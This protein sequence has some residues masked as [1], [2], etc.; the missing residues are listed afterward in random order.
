MHQISLQER[1]RGAIWGQFIGDGATSST[2]FIDVKKNNDFKHYGDAA[3]LLLHSLV[4]QHGFSARNFGTR[5]VETFASPDYTNPTSKTIHET[6]E[7]YHLSLEEGHPDLGYDFQGG[8][9]NAD[10]DSATRLAPLVALYWDDSKLFL[11]VDKATR[12]TQNNELAIAYMRSY[13]RILRNLFQGEELRQVFT[14]EAKPSINDTPLDLHVREKIKQA[15]DLEEIDVI[16]ATTKLGEGSH[17]DQCFP[18]AIHTMLKNSDSFKHAIIDTCQAGGDSTGRAALVGTW[19]GAYLGLDKIPQEWPH[20][21]NFFPT[22]EK[23]IETIISLKV[24]TL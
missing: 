10:V 9:N 21:L 18:S 19:L 3:I 2:K 11:L 23:D 5:F 13:A 15:L 24:P 22:I 8:A 6:I 14:N 12:V 4:H 16:K 1:L 17:L 7:N 20:N